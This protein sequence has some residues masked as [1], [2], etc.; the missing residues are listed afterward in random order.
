MPELAIRVSDLGKRYLLG[1]HQEAYAT[2]RETIVDVAHGFLKRVA[3]PR[4][5]LRDRRDEEIWALRDVSL[6]VREGEVVGVIGRNGAG[7]STLLKVLARITSPSTGRAEIHGRVGSLLEVG[8]GFHN[9]LTGREN[10]YLNGAIL[11]MRR[12]EIQ[13]KFDQIVDFAELAKFIDTPVKHY[14]SGMYLRLAFAVAAHMETE[15]LLVDEVLAVGDAAFQKR[16]LGK[17]EEAASAGRTVLFVSH[18]MAA[19]AGLCERAIWMEAGRIAADGPVDEVTDRYLT[20]LSEGSFQFIN[21]AA[22]LT[23]ESVVLKDTRGDPRTHFR[24]ADDLVVEIAYRASQ[25]IRQPYLILVVYSALGPCFSANM[26]LDGHRPARLEGEGR[27]QCRF[28]SIP[29]LPQGYTI[30]MAIRKSDGKEQILRLQEVG[31]FTVGGNLADHGFHGEFQ[32]LAA[33]G[34]PVTIPYEWV[35]PDGSRR[36]VALAGLDLPDKTDDDES[37]SSALNEA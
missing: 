31:S 4:R 36:G 8:T 17:M 7:K 14:S 16:C 26:L 5:Q 25:P 11:G 10:I 28:P 2:L 37:V 20:K 13:R 12:K 27:I 29:L 23:I 30:R 19:V 21:D 6:E 34:T 35:L 9:E 15:I 32:A 33:R 1:G 18:N 22:G 3:S 24:P